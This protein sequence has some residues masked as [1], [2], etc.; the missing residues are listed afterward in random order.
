MLAAVSGRRVWVLGAQGVLGSF[1]A[2]A[3][4]EAGFEV[5]RG[6][7]RHEEA[8]DFRLVDV[9]DHDSVSRAC[10]DVELVLQTVPDASFVA[11][12]VVLDQGGTILGIASLPLA[13]TSAFLADTA[14]G[15][16]AVIIDAGVNP[17]V[18]TLVL[19]GQA[20]PPPNADAIEFGY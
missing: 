19:A 15:P 12:R 7:R 1:C 3:L 11:E 8:A 17:G 16:G 5:V 13:R 10:A 20:P 18:A 14:G 6:G 2:K 9:H 4:A